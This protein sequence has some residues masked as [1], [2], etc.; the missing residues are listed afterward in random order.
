VSGVKAVLLPGVPALLPSYAGRV[1]PVAELRAACRDAVGA[2]VAGAPARVLVVTAPARPE[3]DLRGVGTPVGHRVARH[4]LAGAG[5]AGE[6]VDGPAGQPRP[7][8]AVVLVGNGSAC[9]SEKAPGHL[10]ERA[11]GLDAALG[12]T[13]REGAPPP[14]DEALAEELWCFDLPVFR[15]LHGLVAGPAD[16]RHAADPYGVAYWVATWSRLREEERT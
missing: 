7:E 2:L 4:L 12:L 14:D 5:H 13:V 15:R 6:V 3:D 10:D 1:D 8:D 11:F 16:V 9:R